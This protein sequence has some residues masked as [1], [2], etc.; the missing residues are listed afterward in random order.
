M[1]SFSSV[2]IKLEQ[3]HY[4]FCVWDDLEN[5][6]SQVRW[7]KDRTTRACSSIKKKLVKRPFT[8]SSLD[9]ALY[10]KR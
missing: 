7:C 3:K 5:L 6:K 2:P 8:F 9:E 10:L 1:A 4:D